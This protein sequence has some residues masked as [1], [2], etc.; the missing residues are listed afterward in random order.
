[1]FEYMI[2]HLDFCRWQPVVHSSGGGGQSM[3]QQKNRKVPRSSSLGPWT[4]GLGAVGA[5]LV[6]WAGIRLKAW[7][8]F[9]DDSNKTNSATWTF[10][11]VSNFTSPMVCFWWF[12]GPKLKDPSKDSG[13]KMCPFAPETNQGVLHLKIRD[14]K[15]PILS[16]LGFFD[17]IFQ[18]RKKLG[19]RERL[20]GAHWIHFSKRWADTLDTQE[21][22]EKLTLKTLIQ[23]NKTHIKICPQFFSS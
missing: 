9:E 20:L 23:R 1:M 12:K 14:W 6:A 13:R 21:M 18:V 11:R 8:F 16:L 7:L 17:P 15:G 4:P 19:F 10:P 22:M 2:N 3:M 5:T